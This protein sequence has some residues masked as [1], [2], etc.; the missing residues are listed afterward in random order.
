MI[1]LLILL[2]ALQ[3]KM[4]SIYGTHCF[5]PSLFFISP[6]NVDEVYKTIT[7]CLKNKSSYGWDSTSDKILKHWQDELVK[8]LVYLMNY[9]IQVGVFF[10]CLIK[11]CKTHM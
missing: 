5:Q 3:L 11:S 8:P 7:D 1:T 4:T 9:S 2:I 10:D 6:I